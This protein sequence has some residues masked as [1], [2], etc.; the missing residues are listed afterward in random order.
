VVQKIND[1]RMLKMQPDVNR[2]QQEQQSNEM[3]V[4]SGKCISC[5]SM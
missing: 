3:L 5:T 4:H 2:R 1:I